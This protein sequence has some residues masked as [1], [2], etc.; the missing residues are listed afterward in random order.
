MRKETTSGFGAISTLKVGTPHAY[1]RIVPSDRPKYHDYAYRARSRNCFV[2]E[3]ISFLLPLLSFFSRV[4]AKGK[5]VDKPSESETTP[6]F[7]LQRRRLNFR[8]FIGG[9][10]HGSLRDLVLRPLKS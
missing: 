5:G 4:L 10:F 1:H 2:T 6:S 3:P 9:P 8:I 7:F